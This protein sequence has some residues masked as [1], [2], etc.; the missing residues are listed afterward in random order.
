MKFQN[1]DNGLFSMKIP[2][3]WK[4]RIGAPDHTHYT[5][6]AYNPNNTDYKIFFNMKNWRIYENPKNE[7][8]SLKDYPSAQMAKLPAIEPQTT[9]A[10]YKVFTNAY[11]LSQSVLSFKVPVIKNLKAIETPLGLN[12]TGGKIIRGVYQNEFDKNVEGIFTATIKE[13]K[14]PPVVMLIVYN[15][16]FFTAP[17]G[18]LVN[19][20]P[21]LNY[22]L[23][24]VRFSNRYIDNYYR[25]QG[26]VVKNANAIQAICNQTS[27]IITSDWNEKQKTYDILSQKRSDATMSYDRIRDKE[28]GK[29]YKAELGFMDNSEVTKRYEH[30]T[31]DMYNLPIARYIERD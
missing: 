29:I 31:D 23:S 13:F 28:T 18:E 7:N 30:I 19:W 27:N 25:E 16:V 1:Y 5:F 20:I 4:V 17:E 15:T 6:M 14:M 22:S 10:F 26:Q 2:Q 8:F 21:V 11:N 9:K 24:T 12:A 3:G